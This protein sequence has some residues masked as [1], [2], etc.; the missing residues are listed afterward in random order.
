M[1]V[2]NQVELTVDE[3]KKLMGAASEKR[4]IPSDLS[5]KQ[6]QRPPGSRELHVG[7]LAVENAKA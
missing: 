5:R 1:K 7:L 2:M 3:H 4:Q 6:L